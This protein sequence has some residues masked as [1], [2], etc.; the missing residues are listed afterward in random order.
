[1]SKSVNRE[2]D[3]FYTDPE[4][5][6][7]CIQI[8]KRFVGRV[9]FIE[10]SAGNGSFSTQISDC[11]AFDI[12]PESGDI[13][14][15]DYLQTDLSGYGPTC[16]IGNP[17]FGKRN[18]LTKEFI[19]HSIGFDNVNSVCF[20]LPECFRKY[21]MQRV[22]PRDW[23]L[24]HQESLPRDSFRLDGDVYHVPCVFQVW[25]RDSTL[26]DLRERKCL[27]YCDH[28]EILPPARRTEANIFCF[29]AAP[30]KILVPDE[31]KS[32]NRGYFLKS[33]VD[34]ADL[35]SYIKTVGWKERG[36]SSVNGGVFWVSSDEFIK[37]YCQHHDLE[38][39]YVNE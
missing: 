14:Q 12:A 39:N 3:K 38:I 23:K 5:A 19:K 27:P 35:V 6:Q 11:I 10:P 21:T 4:V 8:A 30:Y 32:N 36:A 28:F 37:Y 24:V 20:V 31:V 13:I 9:Q 7:H 1:M 25:M 22:F 29:G 33:R 34:T 17:P 15:A 2:L 26:V 16:V 18:K